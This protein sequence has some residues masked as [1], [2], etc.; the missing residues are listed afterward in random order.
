MKNK[1]IH[2]DRFEY[3]GMPCIQSDGHHSFR[4]TTILGAT[5]RGLTH[6]DFVMNLQKKKQLGPTVGRNPNEPQQQ[7]MKSDNY[8]PQQRKKHNQQQ[9]EELEQG[10]L[11]RAGPP[12]GTIVQEQLQ[13]EQYCY[14][15]GGKGK[16]NLASWNSCKLLGR[17]VWMIQIVSL[18]DIIHWIM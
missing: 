1:S 3:H 18:W 6:K 8:R 13:G 16:T 12:V 5:R 2:P 11:E 17:E 9:Q 14:H 4:E 10:P 7:F 15:Q